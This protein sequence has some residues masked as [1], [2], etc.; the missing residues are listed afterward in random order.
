MVLLQAWPFVALF[1]YE[2][3]E[4]FFFPILVYMYPYFHFKQ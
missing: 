3:T 1:L 4:D 2:Q